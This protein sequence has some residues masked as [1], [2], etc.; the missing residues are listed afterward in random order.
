[1]QAISS[2][3]IVLFKFFWKILFQ[4]IRLSLL[5][6]LEVYWPTNKLIAPL[7]MFPNNRSKISSVT[8]CVVMSCWWRAAMKYTLCKHRWLNTVFVLTTIHNNRSKPSFYF[9]LETERCKKPPG[10]WKPRR[11]ATQLLLLLKLYYISLLCLSR[12]HCREK[13]GR[14]MW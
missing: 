9:F 2:N 5:P 1:M 7:L 8:F 6:R 4:K 13:A 14:L 12:I 3:T 11:P 10:L